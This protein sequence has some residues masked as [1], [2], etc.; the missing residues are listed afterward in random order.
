MLS[1]GTKTC[2]LGLGRKSALVLKPKK[3]LKVISGI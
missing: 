1:L 2:W 3:D